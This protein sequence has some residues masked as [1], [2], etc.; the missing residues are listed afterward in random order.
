MDMQQVEGMRAKLAE[1]VADLFASVPRRDQRVQ[2]DC[3]LRGLMLDG[4][5]KSIR[6]M[7]ERLPDGMNRTL[8]QFVNRS[9]WDPVPVQ[10]R[11]AE[12]M[13][14]LISPDAV[15]I[16]DVSFPKDGRMSVGVARQYCGALASRRTARSR[17]A[18]PRR[19]RCSG[20]CSCRRSGTRTPGGAVPAG[21]R[22]RSGTGRSGGWRLMSWTRWP[23][24]AWPTASWWRT[25]GAARCT[26]SA[27]DCASGIWTAS[28]PCA[29][30]PAHIPPTPSVPSTPQRAGRMAH[31][32]CPATATRPTP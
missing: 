28:P 30:T 29:G 8:Q 20:G 15:V 2:G 23:G 31:P 3:C 27:R 16:D 12:R 10:R 17:S 26:P 7:A 32:V 9:P 25:P 11:I 5:R 18:I 1:F 4:R 13:V 6:P 24:G 21:C 19:F 22:M 14:S